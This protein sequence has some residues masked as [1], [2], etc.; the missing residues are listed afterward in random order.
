MREMLSDLKQDFEI[1]LFGS[2]YQFVE[3]ILEVMNKDS[4][5]PLYDQLIKKDML[6]YTKDLDY[7]IL[8]LNVLL[9]SRDLKDILVVSSSCG[10]TMLHH[11]NGVP[12]REYKGNKKDLS[13]YSLTK[14][15]RSFKDVKDVRTKIQE[16][17]GI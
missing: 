4:P 5:E 7:F 1:V 2:N 11:T 17:F 3:K 10:R 15:L 13:L 14:Y 16:D 12:V 6:F 9:G 8:D